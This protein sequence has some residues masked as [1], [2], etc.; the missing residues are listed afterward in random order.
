[1]IGPEGNLDEQGSAG[2]LSHL[3]ETEKAI[4]SVVCEVRRNRE[5][6]LGHC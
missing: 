6:Q 2:H 5:K 3:R 1:M 4:G